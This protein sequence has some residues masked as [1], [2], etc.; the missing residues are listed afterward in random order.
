MAFYI[1]SDP[2]LFVFTLGIGVI[3][4]IGVKII[5]SIPADLRVKV[6]TVAAL[7]V[8]SAGVFSP[9][10]IQEAANYWEL[11]TELARSITAVAIVGILGASL[12]TIRRLLPQNG[13]A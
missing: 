5:Y 11:S 13:V 12:E 2:L 9:I 4:L 1:L 3:A 8:V 6:G 10:A 7:C